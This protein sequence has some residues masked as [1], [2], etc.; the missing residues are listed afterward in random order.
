VAERVLP[1]FLADIRHVAA[2]IYDTG[3]AGEI[4]GI[5]EQRAP[6]RLQQVHD[7]QILALRLELS[8]RS[9]QEVHVRVA[10]SPSFRRHV[11]DAPDPQGKVALTRLDSYG[12]PERLVFEPARD[13]DDVASWQP[14]LAG[15]V[16][17]RKAAL[18]QADVTANVVMP[19]IEVLRDVI[20]V[21]VRLVRNSRGRTRTPRRSARRRDR[22]VA[23]L[24]PPVRDDHP[25]RQPDRSTG[26]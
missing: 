25:P 9:G 23:R 16:D 20:V 6:P 10:R 17:I 13:V 1:V 24:E 2:A 21:A 11:S 22:L 15:P 4:L 7:P 26:S 3:P 5:G 19:A 18:A 8:A 14:S 12:L